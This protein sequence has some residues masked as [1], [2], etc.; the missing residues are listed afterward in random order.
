M[1]WGF[2]RPVDHAAQAH[3]HVLS[4]LGG[5]MT[6]RAKQFAIFTLSGRVG[7]VGRRKACWGGLR[8]RQYQNLL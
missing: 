2:L 8:G 5:K 3:P 6:H 1:E 4:N 7:R